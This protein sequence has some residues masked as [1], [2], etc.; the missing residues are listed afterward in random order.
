MSDIVDNLSDYIRAGFDPH[1]QLKE[2][3]SEIERL[4]DENVR[5]REAL[6]KIA[7]LDVPRP[8]VAR[9]RADGKPSKYDRCAH[10]INMWDDCPNCISD[11]ARAALAETEPKE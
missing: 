7:A 5:L 9:Y 10:T 11:Y 3:R 6:E 8:V 4:R 1:N 2:A